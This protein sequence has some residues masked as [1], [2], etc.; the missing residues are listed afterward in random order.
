MKMRFH[1]NLSAA[2]V[3]ILTSKTSAGRFFDGVVMGR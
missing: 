3:K 2:A 1:D